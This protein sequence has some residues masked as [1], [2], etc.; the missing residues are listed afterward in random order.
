MFLCEHYGELLSNILFYSKK[1]KPI[2][3]EIA[4]IRK[5][6]K[7]INRKTSDYYRRVSLDTLTPMSEP[8]YEIK[9]EVAQDYIY[10]VNVFAELH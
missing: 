7:L 10:H 4:C 6:M 9:E 8:S 3:I 2:T 1:G 5:M